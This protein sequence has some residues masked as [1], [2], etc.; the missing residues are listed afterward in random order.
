[1]AKRKQIAGDGEVLDYK[2]KGEQ[3]ALALDAS[4]DSFLT[5]CK[6]HELPVHLHITGGEDVEDVEFSAEI[7]GFKIELK[8]ATIAA[9]RLGDLRFLVQTKAEVHIRIIA[10]PE[11]NKLFQDEA[12]GKQQEA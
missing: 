1:M 8:E 11:E 3:V 9:E 7:K 5:R 6:N 12:D 4:P 10:P 2:M